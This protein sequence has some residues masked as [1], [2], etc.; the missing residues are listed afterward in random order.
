MLPL[1]YLQMI[2]IIMCEKRAFFG[3][4]AVRIQLYKGAVE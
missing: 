3:V 1:I 2:P 4:E